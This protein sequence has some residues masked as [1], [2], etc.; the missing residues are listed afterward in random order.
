MAGTDKMLEENIA[1]SAASTGVP[2]V[3]NILVEDEI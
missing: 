3:G 1:A 2:F